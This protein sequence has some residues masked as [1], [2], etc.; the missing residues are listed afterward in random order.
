M[1]F[2]LKNKFL[3]LLI[4]LL[5]LPVTVFAYSDYII[6]SGENIGIKLNSDGILVVGTYKIND[7]NPSKDA[8]IKEGDII[9]KINGQDINNI[10]DMVSTINKAD[11]N[12]LKIS[13]S[14]G[15]KNYETNLIM[16][17]I[18]NSYNRV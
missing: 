6:A 17:K 10:E 12:S 1:F 11:N 15:S 16:Y 7:K 9:N 18:D 13:Y 5:V 4:L 2:K 14:R 3:M 8:G